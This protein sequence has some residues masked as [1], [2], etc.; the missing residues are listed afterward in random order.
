MHTG[1]GVT[2]D[3]MLYYYSP[4]LR[5]VQVTVAFSIGNMLASTALIMGGVLERHP[6]LRVV[7]PESGAGWVSRSGWTDWPQAFRADFAGWT[8]ARRAPR[9]FILIR[10]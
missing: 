6:R 5:T 9:R 10:T 2:A 7:H 3:Q 1:A 4:G 8:S